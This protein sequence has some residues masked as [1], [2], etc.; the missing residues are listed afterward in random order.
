MNALH[1]AA[2]GPFVKAD[3][4]LG[5]VVAD[6]EEIAKLPLAGGFAVHPVGGLHIHH[7]VIAACYEINLAAAGQLA[8]EYVETLVK[9]MQVD[10]ILDEFADV[11][12]HTDA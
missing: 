1:I 3:D 12:L 2:A 5:I 4:I 7:G 10:G 8:G 6:G 9:Q 11:V